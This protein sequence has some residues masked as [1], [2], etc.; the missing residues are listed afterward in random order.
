MCEMMF[1]A[2]SM[3]LNYL[4]DGSKCHL[5]PNDGSNLWHYEFLKSKRFFL[6][7]QFHTNWKMEKIDGK[8]KSVHRNKN[9][10]YRIDVV[11]I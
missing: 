9:Q 7:E 2:H 10:K 6:F 4:N 11:K 3:Y 1:D 5:Q 8:N